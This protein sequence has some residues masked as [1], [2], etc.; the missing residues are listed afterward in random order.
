MLAACLLLSC[1]INNS[2]TERMD[3]TFSKDQPAMSA[4]LRGLVNCERINVSGTKTTTNQTKVT[5]RPII[6]FVNY[7]NQDDLNDLS[8]K[9]AAQLKQDL[10]NPNDFDEYKVGF[11]K[12]SEHMSTSKYFV[13]TKDKL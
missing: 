2:V 7:T 3:V 1:H 9:V 4:E 6:E 10:V 11:V 12:K 5:K 13:I 8:K